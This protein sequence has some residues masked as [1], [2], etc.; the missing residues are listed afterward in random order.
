MAVA[1]NNK[2]LDASE[3]KGNNAVRTDDEEGPDYQRPAP[4][5]VPRGSDDMPIPRQ[6]FQHGEEPKRVPDSR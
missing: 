3:R 6:G 1:R 5:K 2:N 4:M